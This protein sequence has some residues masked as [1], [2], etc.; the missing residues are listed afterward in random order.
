MSVDKLTLNIKVFTITMH[1]LHQ[2]SIYFYVLINHGHLIFSKVRRINTNMKNF[3][4]A[5]QW[6]TNCLSSYNA[7][8]PYVHDTYE[9]YQEYCMK[10]VFKEIR[11]LTQ[12]TQIFTDFQLNHRSELKS[13]NLISKFNSSGCFHENLPNFLSFIQCVVKFSIFF[14]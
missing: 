1:K 2:Y 8:L 5:Q 7:R 10:I 3:F 9:I 12:I 4:P 6:Y 14:T 11:E 13:L